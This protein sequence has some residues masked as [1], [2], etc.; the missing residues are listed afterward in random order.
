MTDWSN[1]KEVFLNDLRNECARL[2]ELVAFYK[3][4]ITERDEIIVA[5]NTMVEGFLFKSDEKESA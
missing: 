3:K 1:E 5:W 4:E 2:R